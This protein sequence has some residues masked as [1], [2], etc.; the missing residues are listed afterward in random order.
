MITHHIL[1]DKVLTMN[2]MAGCQINSKKKQLNSHPVANF[3]QSAQKE[4]LPAKWRNK[5][6]EQ[7]QARICRKSETI[8]F[9]K[10]SAPWEEVV[11]I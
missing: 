1:Q 9:K 5:Q 3:C 6:S 11:F 7:R 2:Q 10:T 8:S 4:K